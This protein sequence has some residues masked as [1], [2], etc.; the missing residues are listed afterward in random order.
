MKIKNG[1]AKRDIAGS[2]IVV[3]VGSTAKEFNGMITLNDTGSFI[4]DCFLKDISI[5]EAVEAVLAEYDVEREKAQAD[6]ERFVNMLKEN[7][8]IE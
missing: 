5:A 3:P 6:V 8:I 4:W 1:F 2:T 7:N